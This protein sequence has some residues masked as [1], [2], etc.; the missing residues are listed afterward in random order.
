MIDM[1]PGTQT[2]PVM[3]WDLIV[4]VSHWTIAVVVIGNALITRPGGPTHVWLGWI[5]LVLLVIRLA[6]GIVGSREARF[7][8]FPPRPS[9]AIRHFRELVFGQARE[10]PSHNPAGSI[11]I[12]MIWATLAV[13]ILSG[14]AL[15]GAATPMQVAAQKAAVASGDWQAMA[16]AGSGLFSLSREAKHLVE[17]IHNFS[18][19]LILVMVVFHIGGVI[20][21]SILLKRNI[22]RPMILGDKMK[23]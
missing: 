19:N 12:Y 11:M 6:W 20:V 1:R 2:D 3:R 10:Y 22:V 4:R 15:T 16:I 17:G 13:V 8:A 5:G 21:E 18:A 23:T 14:I 9:A 7:S